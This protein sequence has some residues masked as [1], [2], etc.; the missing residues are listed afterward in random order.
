MPCYNYLLC[1]LLLWGSDLFLLLSLLNYCTLRDLPVFVHI[2]WRNEDDDERWRG[3]WYKFDHG[4]TH[5]KENAQSLFFLVIFFTLWL[6]SFLKQKKKYLVVPGVISVICHR[7]IWHH[8][9]TYRTLQIYISLVSLNWR[10]VVEWKLS[11][12]FFNDSPVL[13]HA[14]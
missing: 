6:S 11:R 7:R 8:V 2:I 13:Q 9:L 12:A 10:D 4:K 14:N 1:Q 5:D 3:W